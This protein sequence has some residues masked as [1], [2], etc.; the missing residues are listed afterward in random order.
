MIRIPP[1][2]RAGSEPVRTRRTLA[3]FAL[4]RTQAPTGPP[5]TPALLFGLQEAPDV[6]GAAQH[7]HRQGV[8]TLDALRIF[9]AGMLSGTVDAAGLL[10]TLDAAPAAINPEL[11][12]VL[13]A[14]RVR[15]CVLNAQQQKTR[16]S[17]G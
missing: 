17:D 3:G 7:A 13:H 1:I 16:S 6:A 15:V 14:I 5:T 8:A 9:Q 2:A 4:P 10:A 11:A 12:G